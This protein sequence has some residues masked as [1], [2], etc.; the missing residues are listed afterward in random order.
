MIT[1][2][3]IP[4]ATATSQELL[5]EI[6]EQV[7]RPYCVGSN[8][9]AA[10]VAFSTGTP[11][12]INGN[13]IVPVTATVTIVS[14]SPKSCG[15]AH[16]QVIAE[17]FDLAFESTGTNTVTLAPGTTVNV[18]PA[19]IKCCQAHAVKLTTTLTATIA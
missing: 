14:P 2:R 13:T 10:T 17:R 12:L 3:I 11:T 7:C 18:V 16:T 4:V 5:V 15:C 19:N 1:T 6:T 8:Q 9:P